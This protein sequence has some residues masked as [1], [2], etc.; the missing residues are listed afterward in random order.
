[1]SK[2]LSFMALIAALA[3][4]ALCQYGQRLSPNDQ[5]EFDHVYSK[6]QNDTQRNDR[7]DINKDVHRMQDIMARNNI[8]PNTPFD[9]VADAGNAYAPQENAYRAQGYRGRLAPNDQREFDQIY[10]K[11]LNDSRRHDRD[12]VANDAR[13]MQDI[14]AR[15]SVPADVP[16]DQIA[17]NGQYE[18]EGSN[19]GQA[20]PGYGAGR[21]SSDDQHEFDKIYAKWIHDNQRGDRDDVAKDAHRMQDI[22][23]R[24]NI[25]SNVPFNQIASPNAGYDRH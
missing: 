3:L 22:M 20:Y 19:A 13:R 7:D 9:Q 23:A 15:N 1:M 16:F 2:I 14:M 10:S 12:D 6:W 17:T 24:Y 4:P 18:Y 8:P 11:W 21:L 25:P 5:R